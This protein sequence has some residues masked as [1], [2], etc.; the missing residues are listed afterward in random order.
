MGRE[1]GLRACAAAALLAGTC[2]AAAQGA[3][4]SDGQSTKNPHPGGLWECGVL[5]GDWGGERDEWEKNLGLKLGASYLGEALGNATGGKRRGVVYEGQLELSLTLDL[6]KVM[7][8][9]DATFHVDAY[10]IHGRGLSANKLGNNL[11]TASGIEADRSTRLF[12]LWL[13]QQLW[14]GAVAVRIGQ[15]SA[16]DEFIVSDYAS[17]FINASFGWPAI[18]AIDLPSG[19]PAFPLSTPGIRIKVQPPAPISVTAAVFN[20]DP[21]GLGRG[22]PQSRDS[23]GTAFRFNDNVFAIAEAAYTIK[24]E[25]GMPGLPST[26]KIGGWYHSGRFDDQRFDSAGLSLASPASSGIPVQHRGNYGIYAI[27]DQ[28]LWPTSEDKE[29]GLGMFLRLS[30]SPSDR[31]EVDLYAD[32]GLDYK[33]PLPGRKDDVLGLGIAY[34]RVSD[35]ARGLDRDSNI[36]NGTSHPVRDY[37]MALEVTYSAEVTPW[38]MVQPDLQFIFHPDGH[39]ADPT[40]PTGRRA[41]RD[42]LVIGLRSK[43]TF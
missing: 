35:A 20:G 22:D 14:G 13:E 25:K 6:E 8:W 18:T 10:Q 12:N 24:A 15:F 17:I 4:D 37:E 27:A 3:P 42:A 38:W 34:A 26:Y 36:F 21:A 30:G 16:D 2:C 19:G 23:S 28:M 32:G 7:G 43:I 39:L 11:L 5:A 41:V 1:R 31:N 40:D 29:Q 33:G 9:G